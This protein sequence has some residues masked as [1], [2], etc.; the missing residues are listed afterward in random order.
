MIN[1][2]IRAREV[3]LISETGEML[4]IMPTMQAVKI[5]K[6]RGYDLVL[7]SG[8]E[9]QT[10][11]AKI[12]DYGKFKFEAE[13]KAREARKKQHIVDVKEIKMSYKIE[14]HDYLVNV[15]KAERFLT[16][17][18]DKVKVTVTLRGREMEHKNLA[19]DL[20]NRFVTD[21]SVW[22]APEKP[23]KME[24]R[25]ALVIITP[26]QHTHKK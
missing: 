26:V 10:P 4:G 12:V 13:K 20:L 1:E 11:V 23:V 2:R 18:K 14:K 3:R 17:N 5:A 22:G 21:I 8:Q 24:G 15:R 25:T 7:V 19:I 6:E 9:G 16:H